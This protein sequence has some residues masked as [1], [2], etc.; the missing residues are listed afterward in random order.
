[1]CLLSIACRHQ[2]GVVMSSQAKQL[3]GRL[4]EEQNQVNMQRPGQALLQ[5]RCGMI[6]L[7]NNASQLT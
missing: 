1:M 6:L 5:V 3:A 7:Q 4:Q 2:Q